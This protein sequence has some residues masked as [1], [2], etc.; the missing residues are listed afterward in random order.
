MVDQQEGDAVRDVDLKVFKDRIEVL[1][2]SFIL[3]KLKISGGFNF[4]KLQA[5]YVHSEWG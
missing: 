5:L 2:F 4:N 1:G 3:R